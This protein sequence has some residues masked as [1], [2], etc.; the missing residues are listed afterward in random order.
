MKLKQIW[1]NIVQSHSFEKLH[2]YKCINVYNYNYNIAMTV[3]NQ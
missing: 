1:R 2:K 3:Y